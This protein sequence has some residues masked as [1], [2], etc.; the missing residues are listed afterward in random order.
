[1]YT[2]QFFRVLNGLEY[3]KIGVECLRP[4][5]CY[6][7]HY[8]HELAVD[9]S[10]TRIFNWGEKKKKKEWWHSVWKQNTAKFSLI[11]IELYHFE[12]VQSDK[13]FLCDGQQINLYLRVPV[14][15]RDLFEK[16]K[17]PEYVGEIYWNAYFWT[18]SVRYVL[19]R[20]WTSKMRSVYAKC[21]HL[22]RFEIFCSHENQLDKVFLF[23][24]FSGQCPIKILGVLNIS[25]LQDNVCIYWC[26]FHMPLI[27]MRS[28]CPITK[29]GQQKPCL[30]KSL[31]RVVLDIF[32]MGP[33]TIWDSLV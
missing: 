1:M 25:E 16:S 33:E 21:M 11:F 27:H 31:S 24:Q 30:T 3:H 17:F 32:K 13:T 26:E 2:Y 19:W 29:F 23:T 28:N 20:S 10:L 7:R 4:L 18:I 5:L 6:F 15:V 9:N 22:G 12:E 8:H 14:I